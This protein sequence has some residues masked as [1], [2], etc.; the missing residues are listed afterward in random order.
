MAPMAPVAPK[1]TYS[2]HRSIQ[3]SFDL[4][5]EY[6]DFGDD[7]ISG[8]A[9]L[10]RQVLCS[11]HVRPFFEEY[12]RDYLV[13]AEE[14][15]EIDYNALQSLCQTK[16]VFTSEA[17]TGKGSGDKTDWTA[18]DHAARFMVQTLQHS[19]HQDGPWDHGLYDAKSDDSDLE[20][21]QVW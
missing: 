21:W 16:E 10:V 18:V 4:L 6:L 15:Q 3:R 17:Y 1:L 20:F 14:V 2:S 8:A 11:S 5:C 13:Q 12:T 9:G 19:W 7:H